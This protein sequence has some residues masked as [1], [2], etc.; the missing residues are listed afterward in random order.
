MY[1]IDD[2]LSEPKFLIT[3]FIYILLIL[4]Y[5]A[6]INH[7]IGKEIATPIQRTIR[8]PATGDHFT[9][10]IKLTAQTRKPK[11]KGKFT[12]AK[13]KN[14]RYLNNNWTRKTKNH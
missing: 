5:N 2:L 9:Q 11:F 14:I 8:W 7:S 6:G 12:W 13:L 4:H 1:F 10:Q 3:L